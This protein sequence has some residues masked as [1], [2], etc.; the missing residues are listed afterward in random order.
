M[1]SALDSTLLTTL[2]TRALL[3]RLLVLRGLLI[4]GWAAGIAGIAWL[5]WGLHIP[6]PLLPMA[7]V[8]ALL[9]AFTLT[10]WW[11][12]QHD[13]PATQ[14]EFLTHL[15]VDL[16]AFAVLVFFSG[17]ATNPFVSLMLVPIIIAAISL[18]PRWVWLLAAVAGGYYALLLFVYQ[19][20]AIAD[21]VAAYGMHL[22]GMWFNF[23]ISAALIAF[24]ITRMHAGLRAR[25]G[26]LAALRE[27]QLRDERI[28]ALGTQAALAAHELA[29]P[30]ATIQTTAHELALEFANDPDIGAD[31]QLL[32]KQAQAC[33]RILTQLAARAQDSTPHATSLDDWLATLVTNWQVIRPDVQVQTRLPPTGREYTPPE[34]L[35][36]ALLNVLNNAA[37]VS[38]DAVEFAATVTDD[39]L[40]LE[41]ADRG[42]GFTAAQ[43]A[44]AGRV[45]FSD[46]PGQGWG[47]GLVL[48]HATLERAGGALTLAERAGGGTLVRIQLPWYSTP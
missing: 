39:F 34:A 40:W 28:L 44:Q 2:P 1:P 41:V 6:M 13:A 11:R 18:R 36:Q 4:A 29:T 24:F 9:G 38:P 3:G 48:T 26:E 16:T 14:M 47:M 45:L 17:G 43:K 42:P 21:P 8:L 12:L 15:L 35:E 37:D 23:L 27:K 20:L 30:L 33:K 7:A 5:H 22:G 25:D 46:K 31:C 10:T 19:T 32:E